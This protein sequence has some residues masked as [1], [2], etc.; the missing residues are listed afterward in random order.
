MSLFADNRLIILK[1]I[2]M[3]LFAILKTL[4]GLLHNLD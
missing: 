2:N 4:D 3:Y 1:A